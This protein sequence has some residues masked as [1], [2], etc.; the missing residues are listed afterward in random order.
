MTYKRIL[1]AVSLAAAV[2]VVASA[3]GGSSSGGTSNSGSASKSPYKFAFTGPLSGPVGEFIGPA[4]QGLSDYFKYINGQGGVNGHPVN[5]SSSDIVTDV[6]KAV[7][8]FRQYASDKSV[9]A[10]T[11]LGISTQIAPIAKSLETDGVSGISI[12]S[13]DPDLLPYSKW[14]FS[15]GDDLAG[16]GAAALNY[17]LKQDAHARIAYFSYDTPAEEAL[18]NSVVKEVKGSGATL[19][20]KTL[21]PF[22]ATDV[23]VEIGKLL[24]SKPDWI[25]NGGATSP[26]ATSAVNSLKTDGF[27]GKMIVAAAGGDDS[28]FANGGNDKF[29]YIA[30]RSF[31]APSETDV[32]AVANMMSHVTGQKPVRQY[33]TSGWVLGMVLAD[34]L[35]K[36]GDNCD[37]AAFRDALEQ[38]NITDTGQLA[39]GPVG[40][41][42]S[43]HQGF[44]TAMIYTWDAAKKKPAYAE[45]LPWYS[46]GPCA[47]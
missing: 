12:T 6:P 35:K 40:F 5:L 24:Q 29:A 2:T 13:G 36:C 3:C 27:A 41:S 7:A 10:I 32:P 23:S 44:R 21:V 31:K 15:F 39:G 46:D 30:T 8:A 1:R 47:S 45:S 17:I 14:Y 33:Y 22:T 38:V 28:D 19:V 4:Q 42:S 43:C 11:G 25:F 37:R 18:A 20:N 26:I 9:L 34:A 16:E